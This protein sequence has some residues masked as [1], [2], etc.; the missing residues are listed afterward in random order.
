MF[1]TE[2]DYIRCDMNE[3][4]TIYDIAKKL[5]ITAATVSRALNNNPKIS[6]KTKD[7]VFKTAKELNYQKN[8]FALALKSGQSKNIGLI[9]PYINRNF[10]SSVIRGVEE[11]LYPQGYQT[12]IFQTHEDEEKEKHIFESL[13]NNNVDGILISISR[14]TK[15]FD[16]YKKAKKKNI[17]IVFFDRKEDIPGISSV[18]INDC[19]GGYYATQ[20]LIDAGYK[21]IINISGDL[22]LGI[23]KQRNKGY[24]QAMKDNGLEEFTK[25]FVEARSTIEAGKT[26]A[27]KLLKKKHLPDGIFCAGDNIALG[28][29]EELRAKGINIPK[30]VGV[31]GFGNEPFTELLELSIT[32]VDQSPHQMGTA[33][34]KVLLEQ[35]SNPEITIEKKVVLDT[36]LIPRMS[37][38]K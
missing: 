2:I 12:I 27:K 28:V 37:T 1:F 26:I 11:E 3:N 36:T 5:G 25:S 16:H 33:A 18:T 15:N 35:I 31:V 4:T 21:N 34:A 19:E 6:Q 20:H 22:K 38:K 17:P 9:V 10:F 14:D 29:I 30:E 13:M 8:N 24:I 23:Y 32:S 7:L